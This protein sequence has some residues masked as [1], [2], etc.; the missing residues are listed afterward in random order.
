MSK[1]VYIPLLAAL[2]MMLN[3]VCFCIAAVPGYT[4]PSCEAHQGNSACLVHPQHRHSRGDYAC[5]KV[6]ACSSFAQIRGEGSDHQSHVAFIALIARL[7]ALGFDWIS[8]R[9]SMRAKEHSP[10][11][12]VPV[13]LVTRSLLI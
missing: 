9:S 8:A 6:S 4:G 7:D 5:C 10:P 1:R 2:A 11:S 12:A 13:F 3:S